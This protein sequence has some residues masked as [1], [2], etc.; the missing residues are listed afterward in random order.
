[1]LKIDPGP[2]RAQLGFQ[3]AVL[4]SFRFLRERGFEVVKKDATLVRFESKHV[5]VNVYHGRASFELGIEMARLAVPEEQVTIYDAIQRAGAE[6]SEGLGKH[7]MFQVSTRE[8]VREFVPK[9]ASLLQ[10]YGDPFL[11]GDEDAYREAVQAQ[12]SAATQ[13]E[14]EVALAKMRREAETA[15]QEK[16]YAKIVELYGEWSGELSEVE[17]RRLLYAEQ[18][19]T[20]TGDAPPSGRRHRNR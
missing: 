4:A 18:Q 7:V 15:W 13:Y 20:L 17:A 12:K 3:E 5:F 6:E 14:K 1:M 9:L 11:R 2:E 16:D 8:G 19:T 10:K